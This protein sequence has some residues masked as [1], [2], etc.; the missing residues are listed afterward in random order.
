MYPCSTSLPQE[1]AALRAFCTR[2]TYIRYLRARHWSVKKAAKVCAA[3][4]VLVK[5]CR[6]QLEVR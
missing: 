6:V 4:L 2:G 1:S 3:A 5:T